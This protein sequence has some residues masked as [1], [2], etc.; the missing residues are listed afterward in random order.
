MTTQLQNDLI[1]KDN[2]KGSLNKN[3][4]KNLNDDYDINKDRSYLDLAKVSDIAPKDNKN[5]QYDYN[6]YNNMNYNPDNSDSFEDSKQSILEKLLD[7]IIE[8]V[9]QKISDEQINNQS[10]TMQKLQNNSNNQESDSSLSNLLIKKGEENNLINKKDI[11]NLKS[12]KANVEDIVKSN[13]KK[14]DFVMNDV[15]NKTK[16]MTDLQVKNNLL[17]QPNIK[18]Q[19]NS[20]DNETEFRDMNYAKKMAEIQSHI[21]QLLSGGGSIFYLIM[22]VFSDLA[23]I[24]EL[25]IRKKGAEIDK[26]SKN[27]LFLQNYESAL[28]ELQRLKDNPLVKKYILDKQDNKDK[29]KLSDIIN[30]I[31]GKDVN[32]NNI[33]ADD[34][35]KIKGDLSAF[36]DCFSDVKDDDGNSLFKENM[37]GA[38]IQKLFDQKIKDLNK[39]V[40]QIDPGLGKLNPPNY[41]SKEDGDAGN[42]NVKDFGGWLDPEK[43]KIDNASNTAATV[44]KK[45]NSTMQQYSG[46]MNGYFAG[47]ASAGTDS[48]TA[49]NKLFP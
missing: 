45:F 6:E 28:Q 27:N 1:K 33:P 41:M 43:K 30:L 37:T 22:I 47:I 31:Y 36:R 10:R 5:D 48:K 23:D 9:Q 29:I 44:D 25:Q 7:H 8:I 18:L 38:D 32:G 49:I 13:D 14:E 3:N 39:V 42:V 16:E 11:E 26:N 12:L 19:D 46:L 24:V 21:Q 40:N 2:L 17:E 34:L 15:Y 20:S 35:Q 4:T